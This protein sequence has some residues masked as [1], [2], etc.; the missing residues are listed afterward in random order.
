MAF[1]LDDFSTLE[2]EDLN[3][4]YPHNGEPS[5]WFW[6][7]AGPSH[8][9]SIALANRQ[10]EE[11]NRM[12]RKRLDAV[13]NRRPYKEPSQSVDEVRLENVRAFSPR[14]LGWSDSI[15]I[16]GEL[17]SYSIENVEKILL[18]P[19]CGRIYT[20]LLVFFGDEQSFTKRSVKTSPASQS[21]TSN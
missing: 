8:P 5:G 14:V 21:E 3:I 7:L 16:R 17:Y 18:D 1:D 2:T 11:A 13:T 19:V 10:A 6:T 20:Q 4:V 9:I 12:N 15:S